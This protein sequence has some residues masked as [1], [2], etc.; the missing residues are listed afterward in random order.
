MMNNLHFL[1]IPDLWRDQG[2]GTALIARNPDWQWADFRAHA[3]QIAEQLTQDNVKSVAFWFEDA[4]LFACA[5]LACF[6]AGVRIL[7]PPNLLAENQQWINENADFLLDDALF[8]EYGITQQVLKKHWEKRPHFSPHLQTEIWLKTSGSS[9][10]PKILVKTAAQMWLES[11]AIRQS[12]PFPASNGIHLV[13]SVSAQHHYGLSYRIMLPLTMGWSIARKQLP[14]PEYLIEESLLAPRTVWI[15]SPALLTRLNLADTKLKQCPFVGIISSGGVL[16]ADVGNAIRE[17]LGITLIECYG[18]TETGAIA[19]RADDG[20]WQPT[21]LTQV[22]LNEEGALWV[23]SEW[24][25]Q[26]EQT[27]DA[28]E[29][30]GG[31]FNLSGRLDRI[32]KFGDKRIS[33]VNIEQHLLRH[34]WVTDCYVAQHPQHLRLA[35]WVALND[36]GIAAYQ[37]QGRHDLVNELRTFLMQT[38]ERAGL[39]RFWRFT[40]ELPRNSQSKISKNAFNQVFLAEKEEHF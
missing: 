24:L 15:S 39:P 17:R 33:L 7:L 5:M 2:D 13:S 18:S 25:N 32:V 19:F 6:H 16:P 29:L 10:Q 12:L 36:T 11:A 30:I 23:E 28:A 34:P 4:A 31:K 9:G 27:A 8:A 3:R 1:N 38:Q 35:A 22:G 26:R 37:Q 21:P 40:T 14:Y 20:L